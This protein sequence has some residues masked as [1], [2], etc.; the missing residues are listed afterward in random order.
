MKFFSYKNP[1]RAEPVLKAL[2]EAQ[3]NVKFNLRPTSDW[4]YRILATMPDGKT[5]WVQK[6]PLSAFR[7][8]PD[9][10]RDIRSPDPIRV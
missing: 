3:P 10:D 1:R 6:R 7:K 2:R 4:R 5:G 9:H 8:E